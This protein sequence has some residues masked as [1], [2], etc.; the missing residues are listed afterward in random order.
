MNDESEV[1]RKDLL[2]DPDRI[3]VNYAIHTHPMTQ[4]KS[5]DLLDN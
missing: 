5:P 4:L 1:S 2:R 3:V